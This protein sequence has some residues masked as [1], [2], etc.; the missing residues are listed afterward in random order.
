[1]CKIYNLMYN[2]QDSEPFFFKQKPINI[3]QAIALQDIEV[4]HVQF[5]TS[6]KS[7]VIDITASTEI[8]IFKI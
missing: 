4:H 8:Q 6:E 2:S 1:M 5:Q 3:S 7:I